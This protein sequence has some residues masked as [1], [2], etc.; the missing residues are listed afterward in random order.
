LPFTSVWRQYIKVFSPIY[1]SLKTT[2]GCFF[3]PFTEVLRQHMNVFVHLLKSEDNTLMF[4]FSIYL[5]L[6]TTHGCFSHLLKPEDNQAICFPF[7]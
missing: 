6:K 3:F 4:F 7:M 5:S 2:H 1:L